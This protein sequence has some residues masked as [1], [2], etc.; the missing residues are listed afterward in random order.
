MHT[1]LLGRQVAGPRRSAASTFGAWAPSRKRQAWS[2]FSPSL[3]KKRSS[4]SS[5]KLEAST[6]EPS[7]RTRPGLSAP[8]ERN[9]INFTLGLLPRMAEP[10]EGHRHH[11]DDTDE[12]LL[13]VVGPPHLLASVAQ[14][15]H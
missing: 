2:R 9:R 8:G 1:I 5:P 12:D 7:S 13:D 14:E 10:V 6:L 4:Q 11:D 3:P 15:G